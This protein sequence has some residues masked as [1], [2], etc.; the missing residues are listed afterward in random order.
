[1][2]TSEARDQIHSTGDLHLWSRQDADAV[3]VTASGE[4]DMYSAP[5]LRQTLL[6]LID[7]GN[8]HVVLSMAGVTFMDSTG[9]STLLVARKRARSSAGIFRVVGL[10]GEPAKVIQVTGLADMLPSWDTVED[11]LTFD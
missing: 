1:M 7:A 6:E 8:R 3:V 10:T 5:K 11:A 2:T 4:I 9:L